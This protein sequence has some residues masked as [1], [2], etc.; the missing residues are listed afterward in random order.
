MGCYLHVSGDFEPGMFLSQSPW[1]AV[2]VW[3][4]GDAWKEGHFHEHAGFTVDI[5]EVPFNAYEEQFKD[6]TDFLYHFGDE[7]TQLGKAAKQ[8]E[9][10]LCF[11]IAQKNAL[12]WGI[13]IPNELVTL[14]GKHRI[15][16]AFSF[17]AVSG[18]EGFA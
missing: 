17:H 5:S 18:M 9:V 8:I 14:A 12:D 1:E 11:G 13:V 3:Q 10:T 2:G 7:F 4:R 16:F 15:G 6:A